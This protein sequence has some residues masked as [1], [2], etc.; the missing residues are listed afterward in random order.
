MKSAIFICIVALASASPDRASRFELEYCGGHRGCE[1]GVAARYGDV[2]KLSELER[3]RGYD[4]NYV[5]HNGWTALM[6]A[7]FNGETEFVRRLLE[8][9]E[10]I[11]NKQSTRDVGGYRESASYPY[12]STALDIAIGKNNQAIV[13]LLTRNII[14]KCKYS[15]VPNC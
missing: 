2:E 8:D 1:L 10:V 5:D 4:V 15:D 7:V 14:R 3:H 11:I 6:L 9:D 12:G 13:S